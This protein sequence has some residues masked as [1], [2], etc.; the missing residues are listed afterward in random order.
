MYMPAFVS[1]VSAQVDVLA[2]HFYSTCKQKS[3]DA[4]LFLTVPSFVSEVNVIKSYPAT[5]PKLAGVPIWVTENNVNADYDKGGGISACN[6]NAF[7]A[8]KRGSSAFF[9]A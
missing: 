2:T 6:N 5:N 3:S 4:Q 8:D 9:A 7:T 1:N